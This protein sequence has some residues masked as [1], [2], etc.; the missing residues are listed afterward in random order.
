M[1]PKVIIL[2]ETL[3]LYS[4]PLYNILAQKIDLTVAYT[5]KNEYKENKLF[6]IKKLNYRKIGGLFFIKDDFF[7]M[8]SQYDVVIF[9]SDPH[10]ISFC[11]LPFIIHRSYK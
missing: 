4:V 3:P 1:K 7:K 9:S 8:V 6:K 10:S 11:L 5:V 2:L